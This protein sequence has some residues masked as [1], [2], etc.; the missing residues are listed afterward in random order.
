MPEQKGQKQFAESSKLR[1]RFAMATVF[2]F[3]F[4]SLTRKKVFN[5]IVK[6]HTL[7][8]ISINCVLNENVAI[9]DILIFDHYT[10]KYTIKRYCLSYYDKNRAS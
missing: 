4:C 2:A 10:C 6:E 5:W 8:G 1:F 7:P 3:A 9:H